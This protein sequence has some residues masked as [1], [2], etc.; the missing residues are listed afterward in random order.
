MEDDIDLGETLE[1]MLLAEGYSVEWVKDGIQASEM[2]YDTRFDLYVFDINVPK[3]NGLELFE[4]LRE[5]EDRTPTIFISALIDMESITKAF[6]IGAEDY[7][8]KPFFPEELLLRIASKFKSRATEEKIFYK[9]FLYYPQ[10]HEVYQDNKPFVLSKMQLNLFDIFMQNIERIL[11]TEEI[12]YQSDIAQLSTLRVA[13]TKLK[14]KTNLNIV[15]IHG[16]G[17][18]LETC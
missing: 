4:A 14:K 2:S 15:N 6:N 5:A 8:K 18:K 16:V 3:F 9:N 11:T 1:E 10:S 12:L 7:I 17:Y 13:L